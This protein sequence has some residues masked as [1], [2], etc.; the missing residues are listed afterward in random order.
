MEAGLE[1]ALKKGITRLFL[2]VRASN[3]AAKNLYKS[4]GFLET[5][6]RRGYYHGPAED[7]LLMELQNLPLDI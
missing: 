7:A 2:E 3:T 1:Q 6:V 5:G 4:L